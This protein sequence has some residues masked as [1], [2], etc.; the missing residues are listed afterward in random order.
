[1]EI[2]DG[3]TDAAHRASNTATAFADAASKVAHDAAD[4]CSTLANQTVEKGSAF[5]KQVAD[6]G[7]QL[8]C[9]A[10]KKGNEALQASDEYIKKNPRQ[11]VASGFGIGALCGAAIVF[12]IMKAA[13]RD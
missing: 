13:T 6:K 5:A 9:A 2:K 3:V 10:V 11:S 7:S 1:M 12:L 4:R 8:S